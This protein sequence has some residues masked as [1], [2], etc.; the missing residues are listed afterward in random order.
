MALARVSVRKRVDQRN[1][2]IALIAQ[3]RTGVTP[4][5]VPGDYARVALWRV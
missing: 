2:G 1:R 5:G 3:I 4:Y